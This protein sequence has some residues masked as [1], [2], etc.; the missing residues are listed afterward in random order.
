M[1]LDTKAVTADDDDDER[2]QVPE[3]EYA[4][5]EEAEQ[6]I[7]ELTEPDYVKLMV[8]AFM[9]WKQRKL[10]DLMQPQEL[11]SE[12]ILRTIAPSK[13]PR[14]WRRAVVSLIDHL[15]RTMES[16]SGHAV[17]Q[18]V[19]E[20]A[21]LI[22]LH[23]QEV[24]PRTAAPRRFHRAVAEE[25][26]LARAELDDIEQAFA[27]APRAFGLLRMK[28]EGYSES[29]IMTRL[30]ISKREYETARKKAEREI[31]KYALRSEREMK[32]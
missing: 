19:A 24:D 8:L 23:A 18:A 16:I 3:H 11:L 1:P 5:R 30:G 32:P 20:T 21:V 29:E 4:T 31:A 15:N 7:S 2:E 28:A 27:G 6:A 12:A 9:H 25:R 14:R 26:L 22:D 10:R 13:R 17:G